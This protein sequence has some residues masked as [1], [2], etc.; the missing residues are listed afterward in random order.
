MTPHPIDREFLEAWHEVGARG[1]GEACLAALRA[2]WREPQRHY[3]SLQHLS[4]C[5]DLLRAHRDVA[6]RPDELVLALWFHD[7]VYDPRGKDNEQRSADW[8]RRALGQAGTDPA[9]TARIHALILDTAHAAEPTPGDASLLVDIDLAILGAVPERFAE[10]ERQVRAE[11]AWVPGFLYRYKRRQLLREF[12]RRE[13]IYRTP[14]LRER[15]E[16]QAR[17]NLERAIG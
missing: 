17:S 10:Y 9:A 4:E 6:E 15:L 12:A 1:T 14:A 3:H 8:A 2:A 16:A 11:Y 13:Q 5:L 7:A